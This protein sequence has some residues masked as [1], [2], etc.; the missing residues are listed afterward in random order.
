MI[1][2]V[3]DKLIERMREHY[4]N[5]YGK[6]SVKTL[7][8]LRFAVAATLLMTGVSLTRA[9]APGESN[10]SPDYRAIDSRALAAPASAGTSFTALASYLTQTCRTDG[11]KARAIFRWITQNIE[12]DVQ[13][14]FA[15]GAMSGGAGEALRSRRGVC[16]GYAG[17]FLELAK[18]SGLKAVRISGFAKGYGYSPG[19][20]Q[21][22]EPNHSWNAVSIDGRWR[23][24][25]CTW[26]AGSIGEDRKFHRSFD[27]HYFFTPPEQF[28]Y[29]HFPEAGEWQ[30]LD[31]PR[32]R[33]E[34]E[35]TVHVKSDLF[36]L[37][38]T[39]GGNT[40]GTLRADG[41]TVFRLGLTRS[42]TGIAA[43]FKG[44]KNTDERYTFVQNELNSLVVRVTPPDT[45][46]YRLRLYARAPG[47]S[48]M[49]AWIL[50]YRIE[51]LKPS[52]TFPSYPRKFREFD[53]GNVRL[54][55]PMTGLLAAGS[56]QRFRLKIPWAEQAAVVVNEYWTILQR[57]GEDLTGEV[58]IKPGDIS[59]CAK[60]PGRKQWDTLLEFKGK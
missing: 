34:F 22:K 26:G 31:H 43:L 18:A 51:S 44:R 28:I 39:L 16:E 25:D 20:P 4:S 19:E 6:P 36:N 21:G 8:A 12:Y 45:G 30:L 58:P 3:D 35:R 2:L 42:A 14:F 53:E 48:G 17:L 37:G 52:G 46:E 49:Y 60:Y 32:S 13:S 15:G 7:R 24:L 33:E 47:D 29:D 55:E 59:V 41:E 56:S 57:D 27:P 54:L 38:L 50:D 1:S 10:P 40:A 23:L 5:L 11:E 9:Q